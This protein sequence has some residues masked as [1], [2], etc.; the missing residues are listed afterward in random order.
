M[1]VLIAGG[2]IG[3]LTLALALHKRGIKAHVFEA[4]AELRAVGAGINLLPHAMA[5]L[6]ELEIDQKLEQRAVTTRENVFFNRFGQFIYSE[7]AGRYGGYEYPQLSTHRADL[8]E[9]LAD[10]V[11][12]RLDPASL[13]LGSRIVGVEQSSDHV[14]VH[15]AD[16]AGRQLPSQKGDVL[17]ACDGIHSAIRRQFVPDDA[18]PVYSGVNMWRGVVPWK[19][20]LSGASM[21]RAGWLKTG[22]MVIYPIRNA[23]D[24]EG[25]QL[26]NWVAEIE[27]PKHR[28]WDW[29]RAGKLDDF[30][31]AFQDWH[32][33]WLDVPAMIRATAEIFEFPMVD[34]DPLPRWSFDRVTLLGDAAHPMYPRG[35]NG[36]VQ[37]ILDARVLADALAKD[38]LTPNALH[39]YE[40]TRRPA[41]A[42]VVLANRSRPPDTILQQVF[43]RTGDKPFQNIGDVIRRDELDAISAGYKST[44]GL[45]KRGKSAG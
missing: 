34:K 28:L 42:A 19:P 21:V 41:T 18:G 3:G 25:R 40:S 44:S 32:F 27:T 11:R 45:T 13:A 33:D 39:H 8:Q 16:P 22:K 5:E 4:A 9:V 43:E 12:S 10:T 30:L 1:G 31:W 20:F 7:P 37:S 29:S 23:I 38:G 14:T 17:I 6:A 26:L 36:A 2:G 15:V 35:S 24:S